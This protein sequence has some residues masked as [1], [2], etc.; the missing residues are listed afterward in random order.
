MHNFSYLGWAGDTPM[1]KA[2]ASFDWNKSGEDWLKR[3]KEQVALVK[4]TVAFLSYG[5]TAA[6][7]AAE[8]KTPAEEQAILAA[9]DTELGRLMDAV[10]EVSG[11]KVRFFLLG[12][13]GLHGPHDGPQS[14]SPEAAGRLRRELGTV[15]DEGK[16]SVDLAE[17]FPF[18]QAA[19]AYQILAEGHVRGKIVLTP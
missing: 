5:M 1:G 3:V 14:L 12:P 15:I 11:Q 7:E 13:P 2:R 8:A 4:P 17:T 16:L 6:L 19:Q 18:E 10:D 9:F